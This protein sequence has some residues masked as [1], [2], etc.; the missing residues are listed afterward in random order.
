MVKAINIAS[1]G[2][3]KINPNNL[4]RASMTKKKK[5]KTPATSRTA[6]LNIVKFLMY[7]FIAFYFLIIPKYT[8]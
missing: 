3:V 6:V 8:K 5:I 2:F 7:G 4:K 1:I